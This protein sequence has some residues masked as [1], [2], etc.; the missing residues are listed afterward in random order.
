MAET[1]LNEIITDNDSGQQTDTTIASGNKILCKTFVPKSP[2]YPELVADYQLQVEYSADGI[3][4]TSTDP[5]G[6]TFENSIIE[7]DSVGRPITLPTDEFEY[8]PKVQQYGDGS[9][10]RQPGITCGIDGYTRLSGL[11]SIISSSNSVVNGDVILTLPQELAPALA[12]SFVVTTSKG[13]ARI[14]VRPTGEIV[15]ASAT[16]EP[17]Y[18]SLSGIS[19]VTNQG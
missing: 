4:T 1:K 12:E 5:N 17:T 11:L 13:M 8:S 14:D 6:T 3:F 7:F 10:W 16:A 2:D 19:F 15:Y 9:F 18:I